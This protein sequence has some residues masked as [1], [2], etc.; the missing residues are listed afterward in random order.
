[1]KKLLTILSIIFLSS[2]GGRI[3]IQNGGT[4]NNDNNNLSDIIDN[5]E[6]RNDDSNDDDNDNEPVSTS[7]FKRTAFEVTESESSN[8]MY[9]I[10]YSPQDIENILDCYHFLSTWNR[11]YPMFL[12]HRSYQSDL[13]YISNTYDPANPTSIGTTCKLTNRPYYAADY[14]IYFFNHYGYKVYTTNYVSE[15]TECTNCV[16]TQ[17][18]PVLWY[19]TED[20]DHWNFDFPNSETD[21]ID[22]SLISNYG[23]VV[24]N[25]LAVPCPS[26]EYWFYEDIIKP[27]AVIDIPG[28]DKFNPVHDPNIL[29]V[30]F[31]FIYKAEDLTEYSGGYSMNNH[32]PINGEL[33]PVSYTVDNYTTPTEAYISYTNQYDI[34]FTATIPFERTN[35]EEIFT[36]PNGFENVFMYLFV[37]DESLELGEGYTR[38]IIVYNNTQTNDPKYRVY[39]VSLEPQYEIGDTGPAGGVIFYAKEAYSEGWKYLEAAPDLNGYFVAWSNVSDTLIGTTSEAIGTGLENTEA[40]ISQVGYTYGA[41]QLASD[42]ERSGYTDWFLPSSGELLAL[43]EVKS[44]IGYYTTYNTYWSSSEYSET[45]ALI[46]VFGEGGGTPGTAIPELKNPPEPIQPVVIPVR[47]F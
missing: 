37:P 47:R 23:G 33:K 26:P 25:I 45:Q 14:A 20:T 7:S 12:E 22:N 24:D 15:Y 9:S 43:Y 34:T 1:M 36:E 2:C 44:S 29:N 21:L 31:N 32:C 10:E 8:F 16:L 42:Y 13:F 11:S 41:A 46:A 30:Y 38:Y 18:L 28:I 3:V 40:I 17:T 19:F 39:K 27:Y 6:D 5:I 4:G 35:A